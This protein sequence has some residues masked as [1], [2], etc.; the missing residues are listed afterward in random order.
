MNGVRINVMST[1]GSAVADSESRAQMPRLVEVVENSETIPRGSGEESEDDDDVS[2]R[3]TYAVQDGVSEA[4]SEGSLSVGTLNDPYS[5]PASPVF[6][7][8]NVTRTW[9]MAR[10]W[11]N[12]TKPQTEPPARVDSF[13]EKLEMAGP[14]NDRISLWQSTGLSSLQ[15]WVIDPSEPFLYRWQVVVFMAVL[16]NWVFIIA[17]A[18][19]RDLH[20]QLLVVWLVLDYTCDIVYVLDMAV[21]FRTGKNRTGIFG[22]GENYLTKR[23]FFLQLFAVLLGNVR[24]YAI[25]RT[26]TL[27]R[28]TRKGHRF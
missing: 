9:Q 8:A 27:T 16:Y 28:F 7:M 10:S 23:A 22:A 25:Q 20:E 5:R 15:H 14:S 18:A 17:R 11:I 4:K 6:R 26:E 2:F 19:F 12:K 24:S 1:Q 21:Q 13:L 3:G